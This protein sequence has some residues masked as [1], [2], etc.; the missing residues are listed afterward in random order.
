MKRILEE[1]NRPIVFILAAAI[2]LFF[3]CLHF[4]RLSP[5]T[6]KLEHLSFENDATVYVRI[7]SDNGEWEDVPLS[8]EESKTVIK[9][10]NSCGIWTSITCDCAGGAGLTIG[11]Q[12]V[13]YL[14]DHFHYVGRDRVANIPK[15][16]LDELRDIL[17]KYV[18]YM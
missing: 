5:S 18:S 9:A 11:D 12:S 14:E 2:P 6:T 15:W 13:R 7:A 16:H 1:L 10:L 17:S 3:L 8:S 4:Y